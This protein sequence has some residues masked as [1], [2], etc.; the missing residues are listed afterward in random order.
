MART[1]NEI[2]GVMVAAKEATP[3]L[4][5]LTSNSATAIWRLIFFIAATAIAIVEALAEV[6]ARDLDQLATELIAGTLQWYARETLLYQFGDTLTYNPATGRYEYLIID[7]DKR[8]VEL[9]A[10]SEDGTGAVTVKAAK[11]DDVTS[12]AEPLSVAELNGLIAFW[13]LNKFAGTNLTV[14]SQAAD[15][16]EVGYRI[17][18]DGQVLSDTGE[19]L[20]EA[21]VFPVEDAINAYLLEFGE[22]NFNGV[23]QLE[24]MTDAVQAARGVASATAT[25]ATGRTWDDGASFDILGDPDQN[26][27]TVAGYMVVDPAFPLSTTMTYVAL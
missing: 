25:L 19:L 6:A 23:F 9:S 13:E 24:L 20:T 14:I 21:G 5:G 8:V 17:R 15:K 12:I 11:V 18:Y 22:T 4:A 1:V 2:Y 27:L 10:A 3:E 7:P 26:Y 16:L